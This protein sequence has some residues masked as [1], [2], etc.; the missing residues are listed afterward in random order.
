MEEMEKDV[1]VEEEN[2]EA[3]ETDD[4][5]KNQEE[6]SKEELCSVSEKAHSEFL[7]RDI[8]GEACCEGELFVCNC[9]KKNLL[10]T[11]IYETSVNYIIECLAA[12]LKKEDVDATY[13]NDILT[14]SIQ[15]DKFKAFGKTTEDLDFDCYERRFLVRDV[16]FRKIKG[17]LKNGILT[18]VVPKKEFVGEPRK[19]RIS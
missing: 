7:F 6:E 19:I 1:M 16:D 5:K 8:D 13:K 11:N 9:E 15:K 17:V 14:I 3:G 12:G 10:D 4:V 2:L 18:I